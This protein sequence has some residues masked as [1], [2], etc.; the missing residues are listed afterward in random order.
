M[1]TITLNLVALLW[2]GS[3]DVSVN[4]FN[5]REELFEHIEDIYPEDGELTEAKKKSILDGEEGEYHGFVSDCT[6]TVEVDEDGNAR[7]GAPFYTCGG[8]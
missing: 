2:E 1:K 6:I 3:G 5:T 4:F 7:L 8:Q